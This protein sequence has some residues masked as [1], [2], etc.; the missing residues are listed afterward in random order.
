[1][2]NFYDVIN[3]YQ[4]INKSQSDLHIYIYIATQMDEHREANRQ[5]VAMYRLILIT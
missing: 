4:Q 3:I 2:T 5:T 1:L